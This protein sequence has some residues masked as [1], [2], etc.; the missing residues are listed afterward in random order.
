MAFLH[1]KKHCKPNLSSPTV[2]EPTAT[3]RHEQTAQ[4]PHTTPIQVSGWRGHKDDV[5]SIRS[6]LIK[7]QVIQNLVWSGYGHPCNVS[8]SQFCAPETE[9]STQFHVTFFSSRLHWAPHSLPFIIP[10]A[11]SNTYLT[12]TS[13]KGWNATLKLPFKNTKYLVGVSPHKLWRLL[14][15]FIL[16]LSLYNTQFG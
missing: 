1:T 6:Q 5:V 15:Q 4:K 13:P 7:N 16:E 8:T 12:L 14:M 2:H 9:T 3:S 10:E 11:P